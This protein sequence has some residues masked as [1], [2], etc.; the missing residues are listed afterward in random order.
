MDSSWLWA[1]IIPG[2]VDVLIL[3]FKG[4]WGE[5][6]GYAI[7]AGELPPSCL[8]LSAPF[9]CCWAL[10]RRQSGSGRNTSSGRRT[11][12]CLSH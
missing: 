4:F 3:I 2:Y 1:R 11:W 8:L 7:T 6:T 10:S 12:T 5:L 9:S